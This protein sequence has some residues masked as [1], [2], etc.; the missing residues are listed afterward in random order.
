MTRSF[1]YWSVKVKRWSWLPKEFICKSC[2]PTH[3]YSMDFGTWFLKLEDVNDEALVYFI[4]FSIDGAEIFEAQ[5]I[6]VGH[7]LR[8]CLK[9]EF[10]TASYSVN[11]VTVLLIHHLREHI[12]FRELYKPYHDEKL[13]PIKS[14]RI[15]LRYLILLILELVKANGTLFFRMTG[16]LYGKAKVY[17][18]DKKY[19]LERY[20]YHKGIC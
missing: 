10:N 11:Q 15:Y 13:Y 14:I 3:R 7:E 4:S 19:S 8:I 18:S 6:T 12:D 2:N 17:W 1:T 16:L 20:S 9:M 5:S